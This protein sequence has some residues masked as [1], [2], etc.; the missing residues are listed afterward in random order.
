M[1]DESGKMRICQAEQDYSHQQDTALHRV[2]NIKSI[3]GRSMNQQYP[4]FVNKE[5]NRKRR[6]VTMIII[7]LQLH[8]T[9]A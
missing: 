9:P 1:R 3:P 5:G 6:D 2:C 8:Y 4:A 7:A